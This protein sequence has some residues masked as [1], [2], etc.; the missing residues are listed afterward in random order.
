LQ[1]PAKRLVIVITLLHN[2]NTFYSAKNAK[3]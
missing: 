1:T 3:C 2:L